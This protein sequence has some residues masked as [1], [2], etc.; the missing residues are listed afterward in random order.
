[1]PVSSRYSSPS[2]S[3]LP[4]RDQSRALSD[5]FSSPPVTRSCQQCPA[6]PSPSCPVLDDP[7]AHMAWDEQVF[8]PFP[9]HTTASPNWTLPTTALEDG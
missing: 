3:F 4:G 2:R 5:G 9:P 1:M 7:P 8:L 6:A